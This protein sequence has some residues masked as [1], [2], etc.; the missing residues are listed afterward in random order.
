M[1][2]Y[3]QKSES[4]KVNFKVTKFEVIRFPRLQSLRLCLCAIDSEHRTGGWGVIMR[5]VN[6]GVQGVDI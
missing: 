1:Y 3:V 2:L 6:C 5:V 4:L